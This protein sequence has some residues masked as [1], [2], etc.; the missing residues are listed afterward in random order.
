MPK[1]AMHSHRDIMAICACFPRSTLEA[2]PD[3]LFCGPSPLAFTFGLGGLLLFPLA[4]G[5]A[6]LLLPQPSPESLLGIIAA[7]RV[8]TLFATPTF[9]RQMLPLAGGYDLS[10][11]RR[12]VSAGEPLPAAT[13]EQWREATGIALIDGIG[14]TEMLHIFISTRATE[15]RPGATGRPIPGYLAAVLD[16]AGRAVPP[17]VVGRLAVKGPTGCRYLDDPR[18]SAY[19]QNGWNITGDAYWMDEDG[20]FHFAARTD[21]LIISAGC[22]IGGPEVEEALLSHPAV[23]ECGVIGIA[24]AERGQAVKACIVL[25]PGFSASDMLARELQEHVKAVLAPFKVPRSIDFRSALPRTETGKLQRFRLR[26]EVG[27]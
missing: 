24:D 4:L 20:Y 5:A 21:D 26:E 25:R 14:S 19:V 8:T 3:D 27:A 22:N 6:S 11:L 9:Y 7:R 17:G 23:A 12:C 18:Q 16:A 2:G 15:M 13:F 10:S 1:G